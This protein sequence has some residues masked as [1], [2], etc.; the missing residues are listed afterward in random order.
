MWFPVES[1]LW[2]F[3]FYSDYSASLVADIWESLLQLCNLFLSDFF[4]FLL[5]FF[6]LHSCSAVILLSIICAILSFASNS[7]SVRINHCA[8]VKRPTVD[9]E[10][11]GWADTVAENMFVMQVHSFHPASCLMGI[12]PETAQLSL[13]I[14][15]TS[16]QPDPTQ[17]MCIYTARQLQGWTQRQ[18]AQG[19]R[20]ERERG[21]L[22]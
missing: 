8:D 19:T 14:P 11:L 22:P 21:F 2:F 15:I 13:S 3:F 9:I 17:S 5:S 1:S 20:R 12:S 7:P 10:G 16:L 6:C 4:C 18:Q